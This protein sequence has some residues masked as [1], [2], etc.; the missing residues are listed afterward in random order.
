MTEAQFTSKYILPTQG[1]PTGGYEVKLTKTGTLPFSRLAAHQEAALLQTKH[2]GLKEKIRDVGN[3][4]KPFDFFILRNTGGWVCAVFWKP[5][6]KHW[7]M[8]DIDAWIQER[9]TSTRKSL[10]EERAREIA[11]SI[12][13]GPVC[14]G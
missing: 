14:C 5:R 1:L 11:V 6:V 13:S 3:F 7:Y 8:I 2:T 9:E 10:T 12:V 4:K